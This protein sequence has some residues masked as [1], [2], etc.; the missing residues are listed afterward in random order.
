EKTKPLLLPVKGALIFN[1]YIS[2]ITYLGKGCK[3]AK[4]KLCLN[5]CRHRKKMAEKR[6]NNHFDR[7]ENGVHRIIKRQ[8]GK[9]FLIYKK[10]PAFL[11]AGLWEVFKSANLS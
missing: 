10:R 2:I 8:K 11:G 7:K 4:Q 6:I 9:H 5:L 3:R 1:T